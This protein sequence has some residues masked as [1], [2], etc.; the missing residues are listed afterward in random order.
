VALKDRS[1]VM[2]GGQAPDRAYWYMPEVA[3][4]GSSSWYADGAPLPAWVA[5]FNAADPVHR[6]VRV[7]VDA[8][9]AIP[10]RTCARGRTGSTR[11]P[12]G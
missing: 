3:G 7:G 12:T 11:R 10:R 1:A 6:A 5:A 8:G 4:F 9:D 2:M